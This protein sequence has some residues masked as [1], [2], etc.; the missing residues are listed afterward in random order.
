MIA[1]L[2]GISQL[3][4]RQQLRHGTKASTGI[5]PR[6]EPLHVR[7]R[8]AFMRHTLWGFVQLQESRGRFN[9]VA[10]KNAETNKNY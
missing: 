1:A 2:L 9:A 3:K 10:L 5:D 6:F 8:I 7:K 4:H